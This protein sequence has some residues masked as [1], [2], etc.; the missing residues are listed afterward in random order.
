M[1]PEI[2]LLFLVLAFTI[3]SF[4]ILGISFSSK[5]FIKKIEKINKVKIKEK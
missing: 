2:G 5:R 4:Y 3:S 1:I